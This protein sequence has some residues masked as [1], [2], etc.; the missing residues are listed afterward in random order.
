MRSRRHH[1]VK[2]GGSSWRSPGAPRHA[3]V[4]TAAHAAG[5][6]RSRVPRG[7]TQCSVR[8]RGRRGDR[9]LWFITHVAACRIHAPPAPRFSD[10]PTVTSFSLPRRCS[11]R[12][13]GQ[14]TVSVTAQIRPRTST[15]ALS[16]LVTVRP[17]VS[18]LELRDSTLLSSISLLVSADDFLVKKQ[19]HLR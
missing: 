14:V 15:R 9:A 18:L 13:Q 16:V 1:P 8:C 19:T 11:Y 5:R 4:S 3:A 17:P 10:R 12:S 2:A 6:A 7:L